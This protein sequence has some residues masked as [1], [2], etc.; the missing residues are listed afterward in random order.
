MKQIL[1]DVKADIEK[2]NNNSG[3]FSQS[4]TAMD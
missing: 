1:E 3:G 4:A 2:Q